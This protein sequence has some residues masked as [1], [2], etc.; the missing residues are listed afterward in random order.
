M[1]ETSKD[2][3]IVTEII[4][5][6]LKEHDF[7]GLY[8]VESQCGCAIEELSICGE[9]YQ[10]CRAG[11]KAKIGSGSEDDYGIGPEKGLWYWST[12]TQKAK[13]KK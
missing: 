13:T 2:N 12:R 1:S 10:D 7:D 6:W 9:I 3:L 11:Y 5:D 4:K 8:S